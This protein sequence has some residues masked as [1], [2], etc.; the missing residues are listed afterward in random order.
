MHFT[1]HNS[2]FGC[3]YSVYKKWDRNIDFSLYIYWAMKEIERIKTG[4]KNV[5]WMK[6]REE[7]INNRNQICIIS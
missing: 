3:S 2:P 6:H 4:R 1:L 7:S 5:K